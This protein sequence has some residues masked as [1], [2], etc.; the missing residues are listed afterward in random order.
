MIVYVE[1]N[2]LVELVFLQHESD[3]C[4]TLRAMAESG[5]IELRVPSFAVVE[6]ADLIRKTH[7]E[8]QRL[9]TDLVSQ[10]ARSAHLHSSA[11]PLERL[12]LDFAE[13]VRVEEQRL[14]SIRKFIR[15]HATIIPFDRD[16]LDSSIFFHETEI[17]EGRADA[18]ILASIIA[19]AREVRDAGGQSVFVTKDKKD[20]NKSEL[21]PHLKAV[22]CKLLLS[23][24]D[25]VAFLHHR[26]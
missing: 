4:E 1:S 6:A 23:F 25:C 12:K 17:V 16:A 20:F 9:V 15:R 11:E 13:S 8:R 24:A 22:R 19:D 26:P 2:F 10:V 14:L 3:S 21:L 7:N 5:K 18:W